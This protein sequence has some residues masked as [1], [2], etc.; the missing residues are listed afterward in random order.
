MHEPCLYDAL[1]C[2]D[3]IQMAA[4]LRG[5]SLF[6]LS[7]LASLAGKI[8]GTKPRFHLDCNNSRLVHVDMHLGTHQLRHTLFSSPNT[9]P[10]PPRSPLAILTLRPSKKNIELINDV[11]KHSHRSANLISTLKRV[12][13]NEIVKLQAQMSNVL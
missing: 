4:A 13:K 2:D 8:T 11:F 12:L 10:P 7:C 1:A 5:L 3:P 9:T 6:V